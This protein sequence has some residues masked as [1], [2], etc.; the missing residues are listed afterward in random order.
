VWPTQVHFAPG[1]QTR[2]ITLENRKDQAVTIQ[3]TPMAWS[4]GPDGR[5][6]YH[7]TGELLVFPR[8]V[9]IEPGQ[10]QILRLGLAHPEVRSGSTYRV[11]VN[12]LP[13]QGL[14]PGAMN[15]VVTLSVP[16]FIDPPDPVRDASVQALALESGHLTVRVRND[17]NVYVQPA[18]I[19]FT[20]LDT[21]GFPI[22]QVTTRGWYVLPGASR[23]FDA[24]VSSPDCAGARRLRVDIDLDRSSERYLTAE[25]VVPDPPPCSK[26][27]EAGAI[28][29]PVAE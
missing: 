8:M 1:Q 20:L 9:T 22:S 7:D 13:V 10:K 15:F 5:D 2:T 27:P 11:I 12:E 19:L 16:V 28:E 6:K 24:S 25:S 3:V 17:G 14:K 4:Q 26:P 29:D 21:E 18:E 23:R